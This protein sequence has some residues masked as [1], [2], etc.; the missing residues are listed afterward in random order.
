LPSG[1]TTSAPS[2]GSDRA[3]SRWGTTSGRTRRRSRTTRRARTRRRRASRSMPAATPWPSGSRSRAGSSAS[4]ATCTS[5]A[6]LPPLPAV[7]ARLDRGPLRDRLELGPDPRQA[8]GV[9][10][11]QE[12]DQL[13]AHLAP[14]VPRARGVGGA[15]QGAYLERLRL[16]VG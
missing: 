6:R 5:S 13:L 7:A 10:L 2:T 11:L 15:R 3:G 16:G 14:E 1:S 9:V 4:G 8:V 12:S